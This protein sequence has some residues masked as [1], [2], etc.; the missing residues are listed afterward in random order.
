M[1]ASCYVAALASKETINVCSGALVKRRASTSYSNV[2]IEE[3]PP[4]RIR[5]T[6]TSR[7]LVPGWKLIHSTLA[8]SSACNSTAAQRAHT[9][10]FFQPPSLLQNQFLDPGRGGLTQTIH[11][12]LRVHGGT[13]TAESGAW[14]ACSLSLSLSVSLLATPGGRAR[15]RAR[16]P[17]EQRRAQGL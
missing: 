11:V 8:L 5:C 14:A 15:R 6:P 10:S 3:L 16:Q 17:L 2:A 4:K 9:H 1:H 12:Q 13:A 7:L